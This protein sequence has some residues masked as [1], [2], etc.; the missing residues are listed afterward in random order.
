MI[1]VI[2]IEEFR[3]LEKYFSKSFVLLLL[4]DSQDDLTR[5]EA[6][7]AVAQAAQDRDV[8]S[9]VAP[10]KASAM[11]ARSEQTGKMLMITAMQ[12]VTCKSIRTR[13]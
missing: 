5:A 8:G 7:I 10:A 11:S 4:W 13:G 9:L 6:A 3:L 2:E 1:L 12:C